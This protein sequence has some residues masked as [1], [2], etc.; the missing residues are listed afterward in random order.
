MQPDLM[1]R[2]HALL[3]QERDALMAAT[4]DDLPAIAAQKE[5]YLRAL[6]AGDFA[7]H[8]LNT[9]KARMSENQAL[10]AAALRGIR[11]AQQR[12]A[13]LEHVRDGLTTY[14]SEGALSSVQTARHQIEK[15][16]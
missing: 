16:A 10:V 1:G 3:Q 9:L 4:Y 13:A 12:F 8:A 15:K 5:S 7:P 11:A 14:T 2:L 6:K